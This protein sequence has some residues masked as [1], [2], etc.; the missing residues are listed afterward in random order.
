VP[1]ALPGRPRCGNV[2]RLS[3]ARTR[4]CSSSTAAI[5]SRASRYATIA[6]RSA[7]AGRCH[8]TLTVGIRRDLPSQ[9]FDFPKH[10]FP[11]LLV[12]DTWPGVRTCFSHGRLKREALTS[13]GSMGRML[14]RSFMCHLG[15][16]R[17]CTCGIQ[18]YAG[19]AEPGH[20]PGLSVSADP[21]PV[22]AKTTWAAA[23]LRIKPPSSPTAYT[24]SATAPASALSPAPPAPSG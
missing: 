23:S 10:I 1:A 2:V 13:S 9:P 18:S 15:A 6:A 12:R 7:R 8:S 22:T 24:A 14:G 11:D 21:L 19:M 3:A 5:G 4:D 17:R 20:R 16:G